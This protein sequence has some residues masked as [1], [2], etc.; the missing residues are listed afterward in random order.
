MIIY[1][2]VFL[3]IRDGIKI[4]KKVCPNALSLRS[5]YAYRIMSAKWI[6]SSQQ[7]FRAIIK[8]T[9]IDRL[10]LVN[11]IT[12]VVSENMNVNIKSIQFDTNSGVFNGK[13]S[14]EVNNNN[15]V[16][17]LMVDLIN[18]ILSKFCLIKLLFIKSF[19]ANAWSNM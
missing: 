19:K 11:S 5:N 8:L 3:S 1:N 2:L 6:D 9:G 4:H 12:K 14:V 10:G 16:S 7:V 13:I 15:F 18:V 17:K